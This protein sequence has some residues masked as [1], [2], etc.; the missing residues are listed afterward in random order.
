MCKASAA[1]DAALAG[2]RFTAVRTPRQAGCRLQ[3]VARRDVLSRE[4]C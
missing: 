4:F 2:A 3:R 1:D